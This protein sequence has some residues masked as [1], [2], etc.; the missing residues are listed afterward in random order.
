M[1]TLSLAGRLGQDSEL[2]EFGGKKCLKF[3]VP[4]TDGFGD[5]KKTIWVN[6]SLWGDRGAKLQSYMTK[7]TIVEV[8]GKPS[9]RAYDKD[10]PKAS[11]DLNVSDVTLLG[12]SE[13][14][15]SQSKQVSDDEIPF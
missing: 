6:C 4:F 12:G 7:G 15:S 3:S 10:G 9:V 11:L 1:A 8:F 14:T 5:S 2:K 13:K